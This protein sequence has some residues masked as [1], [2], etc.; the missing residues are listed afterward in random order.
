MARRY[1]RMRRK[2]R[3]YARKVSRVISK[4][5]GLQSGMPKTMSFNDSVYTKLTFVMNGTATFT[6]DS[7][8]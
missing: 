5:R 8:S 1:R 6:S 4:Q 7:T 2:G 3:R